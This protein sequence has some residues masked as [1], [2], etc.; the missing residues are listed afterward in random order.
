MDRYVVRK[1]VLQ[2]LETLGL[3]VKEE[4]QIWLY[5]MVIDQELLLNLG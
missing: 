5:L 1:K 3:L 4:K 2:E